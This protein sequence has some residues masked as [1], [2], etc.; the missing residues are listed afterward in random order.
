MFTV[1]KNLKDVMKCNLQCRKKF[2]TGTACHFISGI[3]AVTLMI[4]A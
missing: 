3:A 4:P 1:V 2:D